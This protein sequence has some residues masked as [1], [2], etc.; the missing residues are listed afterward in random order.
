MPAAPVVKT[1]CKVCRRKYQVGTQHACPEA[2]CSKCRLLVVKN[3]LARHE[4]SCGSY[5]C[6]RCGVH[7][8]TPKQ[9]EDHAMNCTGGAK[10]STTAATP[11]PTY[12]CK[13]CGHLLSRGG[14]RGGQAHSNHLTAC[15]LVNVTDGRVRQR[16]LCHV[17]AERRILLSKANLLALLSYN[18]DLK[19]AAAGLDMQS[20][21]ELPS[22]DRYRSLKSLAAEEAAFRNT[23]TEAEVAEAV[24][25]AEAYHQH[26]ITNKSA[27]YLLNPKAAEEDTKTLRERVKQQ[28]GH[29]SLALCRGAR[30]LE[31]WTS[32]NLPPVHYLGK[33]EHP[34]KDCH[35]LLF[36]GEMK[37]NSAGGTTCCYNRALKHLPIATFSSNPEH[38]AIFQT[39]GF[40]QHAFRLNA[41]H[42]F[43][44]IKFKSPPLAAELKKTGL[45][46]MCVVGRGLKQIW[47]GEGV[48]DDEVCAVHDIA[49]GKAPQEYSTFVTD[50]RTEKVDEKILHD[51]S[52]DFEHLAFP[53]LFP[54]ADPEHGWR[55]PTKHFA[56]CSDAERRRLAALQK[57]YKE[58]S[59]LM[60]IRFHM[61]HRCGMDVEGRYDPFQLN[62]N[63]ALCAKK[64]TELWCLTLGLRAVTQSVLFTGRFGLAM[65]HQ[66]FHDAYDGIEPLATSN[67]VL[68]PRVDGSSRSKMQ[69]LND[70]LAINSLIGAP[71]YF[72]TMTANPHW[73]E[74]EEGLLPDFRETKAAHRPD[75]MH[76]VW[77]LKMKALVD[78]LRDAVFGTC[79][80]L[81]K[82]LEYQKRGLPHCHMLAWVV[83]DCK[84]RTPEILDKIVNA[85]LP[86]PETQPELYRMVSEKCMH[87]K[88]DALRCAK[89]LIVGKDGKRKCKGGFPKQ[90]REVS[91]AGTTGMFAAPKRP[92]N[93]R[94]SHASDEDWLKVWK[95][96]G[97]GTVPYAARTNQFV[98]AHNI[99]LCWFLDAHVN[100]EPVRSAKAI[101]Y[102][103]QYLFKEESKANVSAALA[104]ERMLERTG[105]AAVA[106]AARTTTTTPAEE[107]SAAAGA[108]A[109]RRNEPIEFLNGRY[110]GAIEAVGTILGTRMI[111][112][113]PPVVSLHVHLENQHRVYFPAA[114]SKEQQQGA[115]LNASSTLL[116]YLRCNW[117]M[118]FNPSNHPQL[119]GF[120][121]LIYVTVC[122]H[123]ITPYFW[124][125]HTHT[126]THTHRSHSS[127]PTAGRS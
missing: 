93:N 66:S 80:A 32:Y 15:L 123:W 1:T 31:D 51:Y 3:N 110:M 98:V 127:S 122:H 23:T 91:A 21:Q 41:F 115:A 60:Y 39:K 2:R 72:I 121:T 63:P 52:E 8:A 27:W 78:E 64:L 89:C 49:P 125:L 19:V 44:T 47:T 56:H 30:K 5:I 71:D 82:V 45:M 57:I 126:H 95:H 50:G 69:G 43:A 84:P 114:S 38:K 83:N 109:E 12:C 88:C 97:P 75:L 68:G 90:F 13:W 76:R 113:V 54:D 22:R 28:A 94:R 53:L 61:F 124:Y 58:V 29:S 10:T 67:I 62:L 117:L 20:V 70:S 37:D 16:A 119:H 40:C 34:C 99:Y 87:N 9:K 14:G 77:N 118:K 55:I 96:G 4:K 102:L 74:I 35:A 120:E 59:A 92:K 105:A 36:K 65:Q 73:R 116:D 103:F 85:Q 106:A 48:V 26:Y 6:H 112:I 25:N 86:D 101:H 108:T 11:T 24:A 79:E 107:A 18:E 111:H 100:V 104:T 17:L 33:A 7:F 46:N 81:V 42:Q